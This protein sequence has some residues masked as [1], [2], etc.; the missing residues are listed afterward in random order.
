MKGLSPFEVGDEILTV[1]GTAFL[2]LPESEPVAP[3]P[4]LV[5]LWLSSGLIAV[6]VRRSLY[7]HTK[8]R[9]KKVAKKKRTSQGSGAL[10]QLRPTT[11]NW[12]PTPPYPPTRTVSY[13]IVSPPCPVARDSPNH[14]TRRPR[15]H[16]H[17]HPVAPLPCL[18]R[19]VAIR[20][21]SLGGAKRQRQL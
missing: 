15:H 8:K 9:D 2:P 12:T 6:V 10:K 14:P 16:P 19:P 1:N 11:P 18:R 7:N 5:D 4:S 3:L 21:R 13:G 17:H 20:T